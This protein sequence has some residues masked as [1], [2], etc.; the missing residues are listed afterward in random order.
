MSEHVCH[1]CERPNPWEFPKSL[2]H[3]RYEAALAAHRLMWAISDAYHIHDRIEKVNDW[4][5]KVLP[6]F[7]TR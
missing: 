2:G 1:K 3:Q 7:L 4:L 5:L 6:D